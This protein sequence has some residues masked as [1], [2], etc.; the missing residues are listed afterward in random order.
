MEVP[1]EFRLN[2]SVDW[3]CYSSAI[4]LYRVIGRIGGLTLD[5]ELVNEGSDMGGRTWDCFHDVLV[6]IRCP[7][8]L[9]VGICAQLCV[10]V[11]RIIQIV[12]YD[13]GGYHMSVLIDPG[14]IDCVCGC[15]MAFM[16]FLVY[17]Q[18][19]NH[20][21]ITETIQSQ[22]LQYSCDEGLVYFKVWTP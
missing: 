6:M 1:S 22:P 10:Y 3:Q 9:G 16:V 13:G 21:I 18:D 4:S 12:F 7:H 15:V 8:D 2:S 11:F 20:D 19:N 14:E 5:L 17:F